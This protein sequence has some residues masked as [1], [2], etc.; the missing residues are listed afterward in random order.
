ML[1]QEIQLKEKQKESEIY[2]SIQGLSNT[3]KK[4]TVL[5]NVSVLTEL[6]FLSSF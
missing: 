1:K 3:Y 4:K 6:S 5:S 2:L